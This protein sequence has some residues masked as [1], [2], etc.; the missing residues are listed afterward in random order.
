[1]GHWSMKGLRGSTLEEMINMTID[2]YREKGLALVQ[3]IP[4]PITPVRI[5]DKTKQITLAYFQ[6]QSTVDY[7]GV[8]Q[9][10]PICFD[11]KECAKDTFPLMNIHK[12][13]VEFMKD[14]EKQGGLSFLIVYYTHLNRMFY[15]PFK[16]IIKFYERGE[17]GGRKSIRFDEIDQSY[18][19]FNE[20]GVLVHFLKT[21]QKDLDER[22]E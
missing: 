17:N 9:Q 7:I 16:D 6:Q 11:A 15:V 12:H 1:M 21:I 22:E 8:V 10:I 13:Q 2:V 5:D 18:E 20:Q 3:K 4:T 19:I 14:F